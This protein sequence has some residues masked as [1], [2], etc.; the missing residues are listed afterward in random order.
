ME[1]T[2]KKELPIYHKIVKAW[3]YKIF[4]FKIK[5]IILFSF[6]FIFFTYLLPRAIFTSLIYSRLK[7]CQNYL[8]E[9]TISPSEIEP[10][11]TR[12]P[13]RIHQ[14]YFGWKKDDE[15]SKNRMRDT[16]QSWKYYNPDWE[17]KLWNATESRNLIATEYEWFL[18]TYDSYKTPIQRI[19]A[20]RYF[21]LF[22][23]GGVYADLDISCAHKFD[24]LLQ[25]EAILAPTDPVGLSNDLMMSSQSH[26]FFLR[27]IHRLQEY[28]RHYFIPYLTVLTSTGSI[29][30]SLEYCEYNQKNRINMFAR[31]M[32]TADKGKWVGHEGRG[33]GS[34]WHSWD[35]EFL[36]IFLSD[37][38]KLLGLIIALIALV[39]L[40]KKICNV[41]LCKAS[42][43]YDLV[44]VQ[45]SNLAEVETFEES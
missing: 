2:I 1:K 6:C 41:F 12:I 19:D 17:Y 16:A 18:T 3:N 25:Y 45:K 27:L 24:P 26:P 32:Y 30:I 22:H 21:I 11:V 23:Y 8:K 15:A 37:P 44:E 13:K 20:V 36:S 9:A 28:N 43:D 10:N 39:F 5:H 14:I 7:S 31:G 34:S 29:F 40:I 38:D 4:D 35:V 42:R 33:S